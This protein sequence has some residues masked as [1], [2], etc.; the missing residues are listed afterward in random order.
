MRATRERV[1]VSGGG[2]ERGGQRRGEC[3]FSGGWGWLDIANNKGSGLLL[4]QYRGRGI[5]STGVVPRCVAD[6]LTM[7]GSG[8]VVRGACEPCLIS[9]SVIAGF[10]GLADIC[11]LMSN[12]VYNEGSLLGHW[13]VVEGGPVFQ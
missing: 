9:E 13:Y 11:G 6:V 5:R 3:G 8:G 2:M 12:F 4:F 1:G 7:E 10:F